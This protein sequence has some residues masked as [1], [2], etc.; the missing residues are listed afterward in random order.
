MQCGIAKPWPKPVEYVASRRQTA[1]STARR[2]VR[3]PQNIKPI[4]RLLDRFLLG[5]GV[6]LDHD[7]FRLQQRQ[8]CVVDRE[9]FQQRRRLRPPSHNPSAVAS[10]RWHVRQIQPAEFR[11]EAGNRR[12]RDADFVQSQSRPAAAEISPAPPISPHRPIPSFVDAG[13]IHDLLEQPEKRRLQRI[14]KR[15]QTLAFMRSAA[16]KY[17]SKSFEPML[18]KSSSRHSASMRERRRRHFD[19]RADRHR[20]VEG[21]F[22]RRAFRLFF[23]DDFFHP[24]RFVHR[25]DHRNHDAQFSHGRGADQR[26]D[27]RAEQAVQIPDKSAPRDSRET[28]FPPPADSN[29]PAACHRRCPACG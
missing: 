6:G 29:I 23:G 13:G 18:K 25:G 8:R 16:M 19:H 4:H 20:R 24:A 17:W 2:I 7:Q 5:R 1:S 21:N 26:A 14:V 11:L 27:L 15:G 28:D 12:R 10:S 9:L 3:A 22:F